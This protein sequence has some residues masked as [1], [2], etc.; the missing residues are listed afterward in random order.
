MGFFFIKKYQNSYICQWNVAVKGFQ[1]FCLSLFK[2]LCGSNYT[3]N[4]FLL[5]CIISC[6][7]WHMFSLMTSVKS[8]I[9]NPNYVMN[10]AMP[11]YK[12][13][14]QLKCHL[15]FANINYSGTKSLLR[16]SHIFL[17]ISVKTASCCCLYFS[18][19]WVLF[20]LLTGIFLQDLR[21]YLNILLKRY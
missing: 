14:T 4:P 18:N 13:L 6:K 16:K 3:R 2:P 9:C 10:C 20:L 19:Y 1:S 11:L 21:M 5:F 17:N 15:L 7:V 8:N 12:L